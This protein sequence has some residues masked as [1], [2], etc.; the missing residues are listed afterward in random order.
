MAYHPVYAKGVIKDTGGS[1]SANS[2]VDFRI[3]IRK[4][5]I[6]SYNNLSVVLQGHWSSISIHRI[7]EINKRHPIRIKAVVK[8]AIRIESRYRHLCICTI[9]SIAHSND[10]PVWLNDKV[11]HA[12]IRSCKLLEDFDPSSIKVVIKCPVRIVAYK[13]HV[14]NAPI[15]RVATQDNFPVSL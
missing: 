5:D 1:Q 6:S 10:F 2:A 11:L 15:N 12:I 3:L 14:I 7:T 9:G 8:R 4:L 13:S